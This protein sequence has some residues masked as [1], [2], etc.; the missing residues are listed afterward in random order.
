M[1]IVP[2][3]ISLCAVWLDF[4]LFGASPALRIETHIGLIAVMML[5]FSRR[6]HCAFYAACAYG[7]AADI[8][9]PMLPFGIITA[10]VLISWLL[11]RFVAQFAAD[12]AFRI[13]LIGLVVF[14]AGF[15]AVKSLLAYLAA[16]WFGVSSVRIADFFQPA[17]AL[18]SLVAD[19]ALLGIASF[20]M[21]RMQHA[22]KHVF[23]IRKDT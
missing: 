20:V 19:V 9:V 5:F 6:N 16:E 22:A 21:S 17:A 3:C 7:I 13:K 8:A 23:I 11:F 12:D 2:V 1:I 18:Y 15:I 4:F 14:V 10:A